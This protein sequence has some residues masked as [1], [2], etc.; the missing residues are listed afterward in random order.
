M[1]YW[2][3]GPFTFVRISEISIWQHC[4]SVSLSKHYVTNCKLFQAVCFT[5][6]IALLQSQVTEELGNF[7]FA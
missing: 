6:S 5:F 3:N 7:F 4:P 2:K 1:F